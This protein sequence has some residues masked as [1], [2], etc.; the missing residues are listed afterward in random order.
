MTET[1][2]QDTEDPH[3]CNGQFTQWKILG[4]GLKCHYG[5][6]SPLWGRV[7][8][9]LASLGWDRQSSAWP[10]R[11]FSILIYSPSLSTNIKISS[12][13]KQLSPLPPKSSMFSA[14][15]CLLH[16]KAH[17]VLCPYPLRIHKGF[18]FLHGTSYIHK[19]IHAHIYLCIIYVCPHIKCSQKQGVTM[20]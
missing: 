14:C 10:W 19:F 9:G 5:S 12:P 15:L 16:T 4:R 13:E 20:F 17:L 6:H 7:R 8:R 3:D 1:S 11:C 18:T 2:D